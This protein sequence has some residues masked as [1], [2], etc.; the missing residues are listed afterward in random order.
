M[1]CWGRAA[2]FDNSSTFHFQSKLWSVACILH[3]KISTNKP[4]TV[5][6]HLKLY[7]VFISLS[8]IAVLD[9]TFIKNNQRSQL[10]SLINISWNYEGT[11][12]QTQSQK[13]LSPIVALKRHPQSTYLWKPLKKF[14]GYGA[15]Y[16]NAQSSQPQY[17][18]KD[19]KLLTSLMWWY[20][21]F[22]PGWSRTKIKCTVHVVLPKCT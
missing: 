11:Q 12:I 9:F 2:K 20:I 19:S 16:E 7:S 17:I 14:T 4:E 18:H 1:N 5:Q 3:T 21:F 8:Q 22:L 6:I 15:S 10:R 13:G